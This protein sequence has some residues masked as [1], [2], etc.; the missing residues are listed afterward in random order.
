VVKN[1]VSDGP[2]GEANDLHMTYAF[3]FNFPHIEEG[4]DEAKE[5]LKKLKGVS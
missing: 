3:E 5:Q 2:S 4:S 1:I